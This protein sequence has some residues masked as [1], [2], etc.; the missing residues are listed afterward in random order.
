MDNMMNKFFKLEMI[1]LDRFDGANYIRWK[2][3]MLFL[4]M[5]L[6]VVYILV[7]NLPKIPEP[8]ENEP[9]EI[10][11]QQ[12]KREEYEVQ[13]WGASFSMLSQSV[14]MISFNIK[15]PIE[16]WKGLKNKYMLEK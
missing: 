3:K 2:N 8:M 4:L 15:S 5:E 16:I 13:C 10:K 11:P 12:K 1:E 6:G 9:D 7:E 14:Y